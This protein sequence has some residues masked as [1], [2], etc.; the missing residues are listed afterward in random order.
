[1]LKRLRKAAAAP[2][3][4]AAGGPA[5][6]PDAVGTDP[7]NRDPAAPADPPS[8]SES[9][10]TDIDNP[11]AAHTSDVTP[12]SPVG[13]PSTLRLA[14]ITATVIVAAVGGLAGYL[15]YRTH[16]TRVAAR[17]RELF[18]QAG[19]QAA[20]NMTTIDSAHADADV[21]RILNSSTGAFHDNFATRAPSFI[22]AI[23]QAQSTS[24]GTVTAAGVESIVADRAELIIAVSVKSSN[25]GGG[26]EPPRS[27]RMRIV[28]QKV[29][30]IAKTSDVQ[31]VA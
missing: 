21:A 28:V 16:Q 1:M 30:E 10:D 11:D 22:D 27:W 20:I 13:A 4:A 7:Q 31:F 25:V 26:E 8:E 14:L 5:R 2:I 24:E 9:P 6:E 23:K 19:R 15:G 17:Q 18:L 12:Q 3:P 29:G